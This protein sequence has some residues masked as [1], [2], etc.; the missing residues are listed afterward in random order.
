MQYTAVALDPYAPLPATVSV[1]AASARAHPDQWYQVRSWQDV[2][3]N[4]TLSE[5]YFH[6]ER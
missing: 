6:Y 4:I 3:P 5:T 2:R 1:V